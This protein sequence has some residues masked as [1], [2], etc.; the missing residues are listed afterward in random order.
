M[1]VQYSMADIWD[2]DFDADNESDLVR[3]LRQVIKDGK[4]KNAEY[5]TELKALRPQVR[6]QTVSQILSDLNVNPKVAGLVPS[7]VETTKDAIKAWV[8][9]YGDIFGAATT[10]TTTPDATN[11]NESND[12]N[13]GNGADGDVRETWQKI[14]SVDSQAGVTTPDKETEQIAM[15]IAASKAAGDNSELFGRMLSGEVPIPTS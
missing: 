14:Q 7:D 15:L 5:E 10:N 4:K 12:Q 11:T 9:E 13:D 6:K 2:D 1:G 3:Q 8:D